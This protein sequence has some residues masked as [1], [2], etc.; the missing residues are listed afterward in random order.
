MVVSGAVVVVSV[1]VSVVVFGPVVVVVVVVGAGL[2]DVLRPTFVES[3]V[4]SVADMENSE[5]AEGAVGV[6]T[7]ETSITIPCV[8]FTPTLKAAE[9]VKFRGVGANTSTFR[10]GDDSNRITV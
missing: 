1:V 4:T 8:L 9:M 10:R 2:T 5:N 7:T 6:P 3:P